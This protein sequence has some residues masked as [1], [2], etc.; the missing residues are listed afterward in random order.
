MLDRTEALTA[1]AS[2]HPDEEP[3]WVY[4]H[5]PEWVLFQRGVAYVELG[6]HAAAGDMFAPL[7]LACRAAIGE[8]TAGTRR[9]WRWPRRSTGRSSGLRRRA[10][11]RWPWRWRRAARTR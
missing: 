7:A 5:G 10:A 1:D 9:I 2:E 11:R 4:F 6:R 3:A 8:I